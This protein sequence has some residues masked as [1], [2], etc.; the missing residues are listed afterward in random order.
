MIA[1]IYPNMVI[2]AVIELTIS[3]KERGPCVQQKRKNLLLGAEQPI[4]Q[5]KVAPR[6][7]K[8]MLAQ[9]DANMYV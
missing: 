2:R 6:C 5:D 9:P 3:A 8:A 4:E 7:R 1:T